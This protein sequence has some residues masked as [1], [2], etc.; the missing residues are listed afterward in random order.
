METDTSNQDPSSYKIEY[1]KTQDGQR[2][3]FIRPKVEM[4]IHQVN[5]QITN[6]QS[7]NSSIINN[8]NSLN[9]NNSE[10]L[11]Y[12][13]IELVSVSDAING[14]QIKFLNFDN[15]KSQLVAPN[16]TSVDTNVCFLSMLAIFG[17]MLVLYRSWIVQKSKYTQNMTCLHDRY[18]RVQV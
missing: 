6:A 5:V 15:P 8:T 4:P 12:G 14:D 11:T 13:M 18:H 3:P 2:L 1:I 7:A 10:N 16:M 9:P 17:V